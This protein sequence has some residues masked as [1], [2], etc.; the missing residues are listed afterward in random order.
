MKQ[1]R[2]RDVKAE[3]ARKRRKQ[4]KR[5]RIMAM[6]LSIL[7]FLL[8]LGTYYVMNNWGKIKSQV[9]EDGDIVVNEGIELEGYTTLALFGGDSREGQLEAGTHADTII[10]AAINNDTKEIKMVSVYRDLLVVEESG[11]LKKANN[12]YFAGGP[13]DAINTLN[14]NF[15]LAIEDYVTVDFKALA[16]VVDALGGIEV[17]ISEAEAEQINAYIWETSS[18]VERSSDP[19]SAGTQT[20]DGIQAVT[21]AR[22]RKNV[23]GDYART[24]RQRL[25]IEKIVEKVKDMDLA[26]VTELIDKVFPQISTSLSLTDILKLTPGLLKYHLGDSS[27][28]AFEKIDAR[29]DG[30]GSVVAPLG[31]KENV[32][33]LHAFLYPTETYVMTDTVKEIADKI[34]KASGYTRAD[35]E[36]EN[37]SAETAE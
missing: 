32:E 4:L 13:K 7:L 35:Y 27:G 33:E 24:D 23:G 19:V 20:L 8:L 29:V 6:V 34:E 21:Y 1:R 14:R 26:M 22:I 2:L 5:R 31:V 16:D 17:E 10:V 9:F 3:Q 11:K 25:V 36:D 37:S 28:F 30:L 15:D 12:S 18:V